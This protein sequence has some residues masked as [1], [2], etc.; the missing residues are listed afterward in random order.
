MPAFITVL[1]VEDHLIMRE[2]LSAL[3]EAD[4]RFRLVGGARDGREAVDMAHTLKPD[5][6]VMDIAMPVLNG[7]E[8]TRQII[9]GNPAARI[10][11]L[12]AHSDDAYIKRL[13]KAG[14]SG[15]LEKQTSSETLSR[16]IR[17]IAAKGKFFSPAI[18]RRLQSLIIP[19]PAP[20][21]PTRRKDI[22]SPAAN[23]RCFNLWPRVPPTNKSPPFSA[24]A[25]RPWKSTAS[26][27]WKSSISTTPPA[28]PATPFPTA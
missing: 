6:I 5:V 13:I 26:T 11:V 9:A 16:G 23:P 14:A 20:T 21:R 2:G 28:S 3:L 17:E 24:S 19:P 10:L 8:A 12:S 1:L 15:F 27:S 18:T 7:L 25:S 4:G 22:S